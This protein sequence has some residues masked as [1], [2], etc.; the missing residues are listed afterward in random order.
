MEQENCNGDRF[1]GEN[2]VN[3]HIQMPKCVLKRFENQNHSF[4][5]YDVEKDIIGSNG[6]AKTTNTQF[7]YYSEEVEKYLNDNIE[8]PFA[9]VL[10][11]VDKTDFDGSSFFWNSEFSKNV[12]SFI[13]TLMV[14]DP[15]MLKSIND[16]SVFFQFFNKQSQHDYAVIEGIRQAHLEDPF[17]AYTVTFSVNKTHKPFVLPM[18]GLYEYKLMDAIHVNLPVTPKI[19]I[20]LVEPKGASGLLKNNVVSMYAIEEEL[21][22]DRMNGWAFRTQCNAGWGYVVSPEKNVLEV[23]QKNRKDREG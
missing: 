20:T 1:M 23:L 13:Y 14:R 16:H 15:K 7:G 21:I 5:Y 4:Y 10:Q 2:G 12:K 18:C 19:A 8:M 9:K 6:H 3:S 22:V 17:K 11:F